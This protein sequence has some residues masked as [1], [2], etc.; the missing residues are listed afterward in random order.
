[1][2]FDD[3]KDMDAEVVITQMNNDQVPARLTLVGKAGSFG[4]L[5]NLVGDAMKSAGKKWGIFLSKKI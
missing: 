5:T 4:S 1:L 3:D 2:E